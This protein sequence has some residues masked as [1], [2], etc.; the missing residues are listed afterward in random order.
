MKRAFGYGFMQLR[1]RFSQRSLR[2]VALVLFDRSM[3]FL[4]KGPD[5]S[6]DRP[7]AFLALQSLPSCFDC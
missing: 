6:H 4:D 2:L 3:N 1:G 7:V 5:P